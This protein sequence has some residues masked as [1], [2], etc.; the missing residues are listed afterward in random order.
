VNGPETIHSLADHVATCTP[1]QVGHALVSALAGALCRERHRT[2]IACPD[3]AASAEVLARIVGKALFKV[4]QAGMQRPL[5]VCDYNAI[6]AALEV[7]EQEARTPTRATSAVHRVMT[8]GGDAE[9]PL[10]NVE[11]TDARD[12]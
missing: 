2:S 10:G 8:P 11:Q 5:T 7:I 4:R 3:C 1:Q 6:G 12:V 9:R